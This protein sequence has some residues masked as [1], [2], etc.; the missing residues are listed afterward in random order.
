MFVNKDLAVSTDYICFLILSFHL[1]F[2]GGAFSLCVRFRVLSLLIPSL[3]LPPYF[4][5]G[6]RVR[7]LFWDFLSSSDIP[8]GCVVGYRRPL[9]PSLFSLFVYSI[10]SYCQPVI[11]FVS[12][13]FL[14][15]SILYKYNISFFLN[16]LSTDMCFAKRYRFTYLTTL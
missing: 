9:F 8:W 14:F 5:Q 3:V 6:V 1:S 13:F 15:P 7:V 2:I 4:S 11:C 10:R 12:F 16:L